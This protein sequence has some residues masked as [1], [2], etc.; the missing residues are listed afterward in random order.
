MTWDYKVNR[1]AMKSGCNIMFRSLADD[2]EDCYE[3]EVLE[4]TFIRM[5]EETS[6]DEIAKIKENDDD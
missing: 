2:I 3:F 5:L 6:W 1:K 4:E